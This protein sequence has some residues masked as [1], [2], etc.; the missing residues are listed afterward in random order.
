MTPTLWF[1]P[2]VLPIGLFV[3]YSDLRAMRIP[4]PAVLALLAVF[5]VIGP[6]VLPWDEYVWRYA[7]FAVALLFGIL[8]NASGAMGAGDAKFIAAAAPFVALADLTLVMLLFCACLLGAFATHRIAMVTPLRNLAPDW[9][10]WRM[11]SKF[12]MGFAL[13]ATLCLYLVLGTA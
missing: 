4:N 7:H 11:G 6:L 10:S 3:A 5:V 9:K 13:A 12:P 1:L 2:F 8:L